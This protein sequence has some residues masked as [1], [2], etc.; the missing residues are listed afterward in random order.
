M[1]NGIRRIILTDIP[2]PGVIGESI[3]TEDPTV[4]IIENTGALHNEIITHRIGLIPICLSEDD[5][6]SYDDGSIRLELNVK[7]EGN[8]IENVTTKDILVFRNNEQLSDKET[9]QIF[10]A[11]KVSKDHILITRLRTGEHLHFTANVVKRTGRD[12]ASFNP[13]SL[14]NFSYIQDPIEADKQIS[15]LDK[16]RAYFKNKYGDPIAFKFD[17]EHINPNIAPKYLVNKAVE[18]I[19]AKLNLLRENIMNKTDHVEVRQFQDIENT[20]EFYVNNEDDTL[21]NIIQSYIHNK[22]IRETNKFNDAISCLYVGYICPHPLKALMILRITLD[23]ETNKATFIGF[24]EHNCKL[25]IDEMNKI[26]LEWNKFAL[27][28]HVV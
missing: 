16:E 26:K 2:I 13:V 22:Y 27:D 7:N 24:L 20:Y 6:D 11:N 4:N 23:D 28:N 18:T 19:I 21:G 12:N 10:P 15:V 9:V 1:V 25:I 3:G 5:V 8:K 14:C 17:I